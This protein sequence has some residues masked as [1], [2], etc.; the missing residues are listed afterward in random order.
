[1]NSRGQHSMG[2]AAALI[3]GRLAQRFGWVLVV[4]VGRHKGAERAQLIAYCT[5]TQAEWRWFGQRSLQGHRQC[6]KVLVA[7]WKC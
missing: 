1:M 3:R 4:I 6:G 7:W 2:L 5:G